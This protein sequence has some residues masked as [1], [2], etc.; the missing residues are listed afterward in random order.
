MN[1]APDSDESLIG[2]HARGDVAAFETLYRRN[3]LRTWRFLER[4]IG[5]HAVADELMQDVWFTVAKEAV[6]YQPATRFATWLFAIAHNRATEREKANRLSG[7]SMT[8]VSGEE[9]STLVQAMAQLPRE[10]RESYL[11]QLEG[12]LTV[13]EIAAITNCA[14]EMTQ[15]RLHYARTKLRE[16]LSE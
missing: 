10:Q 6:G 16:L 3:E 9:T 2:R 13:D 14:A 11:L 4:Y 7:A 8:P 1:H 5:N 15:A 12:E